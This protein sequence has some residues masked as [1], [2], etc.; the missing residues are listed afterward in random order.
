MLYHGDATPAWTLTPTW[1]RKCEWATIYYRFD[2]GILAA[3]ALARLVCG[4]GFH[5]NMPRLDASWLVASM[6]CLVAPQ[7]AFTVLIAMS[8]LVNHAVR[9]RKK[10]WSLPVMGDDHQPMGVLRQGLRSF[11]P[12]K[13]ANPSA[14][15]RNLNIAVVLTMAVFSREPQPVTWAALLSLTAL[16]APFWANRQPASFLSAGP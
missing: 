13:T 7:K 10:R 15:R 6:A 12:C 3:T 1:R 8:Q 11:R 5:H 4:L 2:D 9:V 14:D 16:F